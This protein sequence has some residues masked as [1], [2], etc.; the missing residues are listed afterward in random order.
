[1]RRDCNRPGWV[2]LAF[3]CRKAMGL[4]NLSI[5][6]PFLVKSSPTN[7]AFV[8][9]LFHPFL[10][11]LP[12]LTTLNIS[13]SAIP[14]TLGRGTA[15][16]PALSF[17]F[18]L[19]ALLRTLAWFFSSLSRRYEGSA[20][21]FSLALLGPVLTFLSSCAL[22]SFRR[23]TFS[24]YRWAWSSLAFLPCRDWATLLLL[25][26][27]LA[28]FLRARSSASRRLP[29]LRMC[30]STVVPSHLRLSRFE[31]GVAVGGCDEEDRAWEL[32]GTWAR[33]PSAGWT[34]GQSRAS[35]RR[36]MLVLRHGGSLLLL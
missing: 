11:V 7:V 21:L 26:A 36:T 16:L 28:C 35:N 1:V 15:N 3:F 34:D 8:T 20:S 27:S 22:S 17:R 5:L 25:W 4:I 31:G 12:V 30:S 14:L 10:F 6:G 29:C 23:A 24:E 2:T 32:T 19:S 13:S 18:C 33:N 9:I